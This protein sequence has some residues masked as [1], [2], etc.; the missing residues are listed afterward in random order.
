M[1]SSGIGGSIPVE[2]GSMTSWKV[3][4]LSTNEISGEL[5]TEIGK[6]ANTITELVLFS[7]NLNGKLRFFYA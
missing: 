4:D 2:I 1:A 3:L 5:P 7:N 6:L